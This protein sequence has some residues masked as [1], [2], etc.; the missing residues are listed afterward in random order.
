MTFKMSV[1]PVPAL[2]HSQKWSLSLHRCRGGQ[3][4]WAFLTFT[5]SLGR[6]TTHLSSV[7][8]SVCTSDLMPLRLTWKLKFVTTVHRFLELFFLSFFFNRLQL[9]ST[10]TTSTFT[11]SGRFSS[12]WKCFTMATSRWIVARRSLLWM[13]D[14]QTT[15]NKHTKKK[16][17]K[18]TLYWCD[19]TQ[20]HPVWKQ[21]QKIKIWGK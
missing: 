20:H 15:E 17:K 9:T 4:R 21:R 8:T 5:E 19:K 3:R 14:R 2:T 11:F 16:K 10:T 12:A 6:E 1:Q 18:V 7:R 13:T